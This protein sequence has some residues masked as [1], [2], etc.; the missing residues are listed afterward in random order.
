MIFLCLVNNFT[1]IMFM[2]QM[3]NKIKIGVSIFLYLSCSGEF[4]SSL[5]LL[6]VA[7]GYLFPYFAAE[8]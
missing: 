7:M 3:K 6:A 2:I 4:L 8:S 5:A 1:K